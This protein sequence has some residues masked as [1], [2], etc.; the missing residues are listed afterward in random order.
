MHPNKQHK[1]VCILYAIAKGGELETRVGSPI[2]APIDT[3]E[4]NIF[5][6]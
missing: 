2:S 6:G 5:D 4:V 1:S 3:L